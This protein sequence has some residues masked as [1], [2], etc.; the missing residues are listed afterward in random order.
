MSLWTEPVEV[1]AE[2]YM[3]VPVGTYPF[4][5]EYGVVLNTVLGRSS[6]FQ[7][8]SEDGT[9]YALY[10]DYEDCEVVVAEDGITITAIIGGVEHVVTYSGTNRLK[11][12]SIF[13][14]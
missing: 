13:N 1:D 9:E 6:Y 4:N 14:I 12:D 5:A 10:A 2:G 11:V 3:T 7:S 8:V